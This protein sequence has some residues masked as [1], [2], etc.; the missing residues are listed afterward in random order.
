MASLTKTFHRESERIHSDHY[1][2]NEELHALG[3]ALDHLQKDFTNPA[4]L[5]AAKEIQMLAKHMAD[6]LPGHFQRE[7]RQILTTVA[8]VSPELDFFAREMKRQHVDLTERMRRFCSAINQMSNPVGLKE[9]V[10]LVRREGKEFA[11]EL[12]TH[13]AIEEQELKG[14]L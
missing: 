4:S 14:F 11:H 8:E 6:E 13:I 7:E 9:T 12:T 3:I 5:S 2:M 1:Q 10:E